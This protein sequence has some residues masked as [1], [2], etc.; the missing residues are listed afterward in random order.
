MVNADLGAVA[1]IGWVDEM[2][3]E[4]FAETYPGERDFNVSNTPS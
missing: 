1:E 2:H 3:L 4:I